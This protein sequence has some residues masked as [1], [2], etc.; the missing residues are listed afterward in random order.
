MAQ[1]LTIV[2]IIDAPREKVWKAWTEF[3]Q[4]KQW[5]GQPKG[6]TMPYAKLD[7][8]LGG[9]FHYQV[10]LPDGTKIWGK[11]IYREIVENEKL[12]F[13]DCFADEEGNAVITKDTP[14]MHVSATFEAQGDKTKLTLI[15]SG[16]TGD[17]HTIDQYKEGWSQCL[18]RLDT[19]VSSL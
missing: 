14:L 4:L 18:D 16:I 8:R 19:T 7:F 6:A 5:W 10:L 9:S 17:L 11:K 2:R 3:D 15:H 12:F 13:D 1:D